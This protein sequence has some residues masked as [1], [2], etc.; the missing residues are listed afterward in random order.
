M[1]LIIGFEEAMEME[2]KKVV[3][4]DVKKV[5]ALLQSIEDHE[6][7]RNKLEEEIHKI[8]VNIHKQKLKLQELLV[9]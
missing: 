8:E 5:N 3:I 2:N 6:D 4:K 7:R 9:D 1:M